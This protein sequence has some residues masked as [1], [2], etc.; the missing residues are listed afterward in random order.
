M[1]HNDTQPHISSIFEAQ[2]GLDN[3]DW[4]S[5]MKR[6]MM[7]PALISVVAA[8]IVWMLFHFMGRRASMKV[9]SDSKAVEKTCAEPV[10]DTKMSENISVVGPSTSLR[11][12][13][14]INFSRNCPP[15]VEL[16][17]EVEVIEL[18]T[19]ERRFGAKLKTPC[20]KNVVPS[21]T[22][23]KRSAKKSTPSPDIAFVSPSMKRG[24]GGAESMKEVTTTP[25]RRSSRL[26]NKA[27]SP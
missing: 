25:V 4:I 10:E 5:Q 19:P 2:N 18:S 7:A 17:G 24:N 27:M 12:N 14:N 13:D 21:T 6:V 16:L 8:A 9:S 3:M 22:P 23:L 26:R 11:L 15:V 1:E 20:V